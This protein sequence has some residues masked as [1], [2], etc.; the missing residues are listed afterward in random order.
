MILKREVLA[1]EARKLIDMHD[2]WDSL[3]C[4]VTLHPDGEGGLRPGTWV[5]VD[6]AIDPRQYP[7]LIAR[8][9]SE[10]QDRMPGDAAYAY[11]FQGE[12]FGLTAPPPRG[13]GRGAGTVR[14]GQDDADLPRAAR[15]DRVR[16]RVGRGHPRPRLAVLQ[17]PRHRRGA[18]GIPRAWR[19]GGR[20]D[21]GRPD[22]DRQGN[23]RRRLGH[24]A[25]PRRTELR[26]DRNG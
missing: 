18:G 11:A 3:H 25:S 24:A 9:A 4:I 26:G 16:L 13:A 21:R 20:R 15:R 23:R 6:P 17:A 10:T 8:A 7:A 2:E 5:A 22:Q 1:A 19:H 14:A 12:F